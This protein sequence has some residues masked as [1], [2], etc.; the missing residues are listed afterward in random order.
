MRI[1]ISLEVAALSSLE[2][3]STTEGDDHASIIDSQKELSKKATDTYRTFTPHCT[4]TLQPRIAKLRYL[5][6]READLHFGGE[7]MKQENRRKNNVWQFRHP[8]KRDSL[9]RAA[10]SLLLPSP[11]APLNA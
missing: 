1:L 11:Q 6:Y 7:R 3:L 4:S 8:L 5:L 9:T 10:S 2:V